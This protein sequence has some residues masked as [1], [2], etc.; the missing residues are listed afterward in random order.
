M[1]QRI[2]A[3][4]HIDDAR[5]WVARANGIATALSHLAHAQIA[6]EP[7]TIARLLRHIEQADE[8]L[9]RVERAVSKHNEQTAR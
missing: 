7:A 5:L 8:E 4:G 9:Q 3:L 6:P 2:G 1:V